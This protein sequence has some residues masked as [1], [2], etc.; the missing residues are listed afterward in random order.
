MFILKSSIMKKQTTN[1]PIENSNKIVSSNCLE[2][3]SIVLN[4]YCHILD[5]IFA[6]NI[7]VEAAAAKAKTEAVCR[8]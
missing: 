1:K 2:F 3:T 4:Y 8:G 6:H 7:L 5:P